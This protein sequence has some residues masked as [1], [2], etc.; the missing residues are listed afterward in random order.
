MS[1]FLIENTVPE[2]ILALKI[3]SQ[4]FSRAKLWNACLIDE[5]IIEKVVNGLS[6]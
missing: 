6:M 1:F 3:F 5:Q 2:L 4:V